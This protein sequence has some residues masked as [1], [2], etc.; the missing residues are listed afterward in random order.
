MGSQM[1][2]LQLKARESGVA[3]GRGGSSA[4]RG[5]CK[6]SNCNRWTASIKDP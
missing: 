6:K 1:Q 3:A 4:Y 5:V 2:E